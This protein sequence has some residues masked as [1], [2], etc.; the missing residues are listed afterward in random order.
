MFSAGKQ[1]SEAESWVWLFDRCLCIRDCARRDRNMASTD[2]CCHER[3]TQFNLGSPVAEIIHRLGSTSSESSS[4]GAG[5]SGRVHDV[6]FNDQ[7]ALT[8]AFYRM[9]KI[10][11]NRHCV[12]FMWGRQA[13]P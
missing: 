11:L 10:S 2:R 8:R 5:H 6:V 9:L 1:E 12:I 7:G 3:N 4:A 13:H